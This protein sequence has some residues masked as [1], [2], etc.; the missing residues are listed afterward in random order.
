MYQGTELNF[1]EVPIRR[2]QVSP[3]PLV[4]GD[5]VE[6]AAIEA[7]VDALEAGGPSSEGLSRAKGSFLY[8]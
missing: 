8:G 3:G 1:S 2:G 5:G 6:V 4:V 7:R